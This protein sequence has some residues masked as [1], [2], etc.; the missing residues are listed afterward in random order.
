MLGF[1]EFLS[2]TGASELISK[3]FIPT[4]NGNIKLSIHRVTG[5]KSNHYHNFG[6]GEVG[7]GVRHLVIKILQ[8][9]KYGNRAIV[10]IIIAATAYWVRSKT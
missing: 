2:P 3:L 7:V 4:G 5:F 8:T 1:Y 10:V 6:L 9:V